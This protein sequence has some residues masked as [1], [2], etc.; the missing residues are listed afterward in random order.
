LP[1]VATEATTGPETGPVLFDKSADTSRASRDKVRLVIAAAPLPVVLMRADR[2]AGPPGRRTRSL[3]RRAGPDRAEVARWFDS[4]A[5][6]APS[7]H[8]V[9]LSAGFLQ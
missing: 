1:P 5:D 9:L 4:T 2:M 7:R 6:V 3:C 8:A